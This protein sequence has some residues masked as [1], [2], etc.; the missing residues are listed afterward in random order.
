MP[1]MIITEESLSVKVDITINTKSDV[2][3]A[4]DIDTVIVPVGFFESTKTKYF[5]AQ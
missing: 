4:L 1:M 5:G 3:V 2:C